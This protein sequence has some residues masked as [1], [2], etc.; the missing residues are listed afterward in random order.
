MPKFTGYQKA[1]ARGN[2]LSI[3]SRARTH[4]SN[5]GVEQT[6][7]RRHDFLAGAPDAG[8]PLTLSGLDYL[9]IKFFR[10]RRSFGAGSDDP[11]TATVGNNYQNGDVFNGSTIS[12]FNCLIRLTN[13]S[14]ADPLTL[15]IYKF[16]FS[17]WDVLVFN[18]LNPANS[19]FT[20]SQA[21]TNEGEI[22]I[23][24]ILSSA[25]NENSILNRKFNQHYAQ[26]LGE[27]TLAQEGSGKETVELSFKGVPP[28]CKR[29]QSGMFYGICLANDS[30]KNEGRTVSMDYSYFGHFL[31]HPSSNRLPWLA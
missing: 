11:P 21:S 13:K 28:K 12:D 26:K 6:A 10:F 1:R 9:A 30:D 17:F 4:G 19:P 16:V 27:I 7:V 15:T 31:E 5:Y 24:A 2:D 18:T 29:S 8:T 23:K 22:D 3:G 14:N 25:L 20:F